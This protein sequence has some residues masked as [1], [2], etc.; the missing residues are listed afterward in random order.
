MAH[1]PRKPY[2]NAVSVRETEAALQRVQEQVQKLRDEEDRLE[3]VLRQLTKHSKLTHTLLRLKALDPSPPFV[4]ILRDNV[5]A[6]GLLRGED[7]I[8]LAALNDDF[9]GCSI[10]LLNVGVHLHSDDLEAASWES[11]ISETPGWLTDENVPMTPAGREMTD[12]ARLLQGLP[13]VYGGDELPGAIDST[14]HIRPFSSYQR[15]LQEFANL[16]WSV[17]LV[18]RNPVDVGLGAH[19][20]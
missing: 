11:A 15:D 1:Q 7:A 9:R 12:A 16:A 13:C 17:L 5:P 18:S 4:V 2:T 14:V 3:A 8:T 10:R 6:D 19:D 20:Q